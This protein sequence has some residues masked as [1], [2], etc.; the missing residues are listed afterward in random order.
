M[1]HVCTMNMYVH[2]LYNYVSV[3]V[4]MC[5]FFVIQLERERRVWTF[6]MCISF[7]C[8][9]W[10]YAFFSFQHVMFE[11][12][13]MWFQGTPQGIPQGIQPGLRG[14]SQEG[15]GWRLQWFGGHGQ[16]PHGWA[17]SRAARLLLLIIHTASYQQCI[18]KNSIL[19]YSYI[20]I[21]LLSI[22]NIYRYICI[23]IYIWIINIYMCVC[24]YAYSI[25]I[26]NI[27]I[28]CSIY[29]DEFD[30]DRCNCDATGMIETWVRRIIPK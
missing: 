23:Y 13:L 10:S 20:Y 30:H 15:A 9:C 11:A 12:Q 8:T 6:T 5:V 2:I 19:L 16:G 24:A 14:L 28:L 25:D 1:I 29:W 7:H 3:C 18:A 4:G 27:T 26:I 17:A 21:V 22:Y